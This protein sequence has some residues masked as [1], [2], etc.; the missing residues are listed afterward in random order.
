VVVACQQTTVDDD[1]S[2]PVEVELGVTRGTNQRFVK[3]LRMHM[4][5]RT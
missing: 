1:N 2:V 5:T 4:H 3:I